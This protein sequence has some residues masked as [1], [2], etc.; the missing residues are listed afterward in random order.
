MTDTDADIYRYRTFRWFESIHRNA[1]SNEMRTAARV[2]DG[3]EVFKAGMDKHFDAYLDY[4]TTDPGLAD[5]LRIHEASTGIHKDPFERPAVFDQILDYHKLTANNPDA[6]RRKMAGRK[7]VVYCVHPYTQFIIEGICSMAEFTFFSLRS[8]HDIRTTRSQILDKFNNPQ[9]RVD[10][11]LSTMRILGHGVELHSDCSDMVIFEMPN[12]IPIM[13]TAIG[14][15]HRTGQRRSQDVSFLT[16][17]KSY[18]DYTFHRQYRKYAISLLATGVLSPQLDQ[19]VCS[20]RKDWEAFTA[21]P[22]GKK[23]CR[24]AERERGPLPPPDHQ[25]H[26]L[27]AA[28]ELARQLLGARYNRSYILWVFLKKRAPFG[29]SYEFIFIPQ[30]ELWAFA[31][32]NF[33]QATARGKSILLEVLQHPSAHQ[34]DEPSG[35]DTQST[36][37]EPKKDSDAQPKQSNV[38]T[39]GETPGVSDAKDK[40]NGSTPQ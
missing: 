9:V 23:A 2:S 28:G 11:L 19:L 40:P 25:V 18:D 16:L 38:K 37:D 10:F 33:E 36:S 34:D 30:M 35:E 8:K 17:A 21:S 31:A 26:Q 14:R 22:A 5:L 20:D 7:V 1:N 6:E 24:E 32:E 15:I 3:N 39:E 13:L 4:M 27:Y 12:N 29:S